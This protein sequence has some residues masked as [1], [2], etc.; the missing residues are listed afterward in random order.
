MDERIAKI[1]TA[2]RDLAASILALTGDDRLLVS[3]HGWN[4]PALNRH[5]LANMSEM[6]AIKMDAVA[7][8][9]IHEKYDPQPI[10]NKMAEFK[11][12]TLP[13]L[14]SANGVYAVP[15]YL[16]LLDYITSFFGPVFVVKT[17]WEKSVEAGS[18][19]KTISGKLLSY[20]S[21]IKKFDADFAELGGKID[22]INAAHDAATSLP[23]DMDELREARHSVI[24]LRTSAEKSEIL[25]K[26]ALDIIN[27]YLET[28]KIKEA[29]AT[30]LV[31][32]TEDA[33]S[34]ATTRGLGE[35]FQTRAHE[36]SRSMLYWVGGLVLA[37]GAGA[38]VGTLRIWAVQDLMSRNVSNEHLNIALVLAL[39]SIAGPIWFAWIATKQIGHRFRLAED[40]AFK[41]SVAKAYE[42]YRREAARIDPSFSARL[43]GSALD[44]IDEAPIRFVENHTP[45]TPWQDIFSW[46]RKGTPDA[47]NGT[48]PTRKT[49]QEE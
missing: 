35:A 25:A 11:A 33:Y 28:I 23:T 47:S 7:L 38:V 37:L 22:E 3:V 27:G 41:A 36:L 42:G 29:E 39:I 10:L 46:G 44:R 21:R 1:A 20:K 48:P 19:P 40:Y 4:L 31:Q 17:D 45:G 49:E 24:E 34:A 8:E 14:T 18:L 32:N 6:L 5:D 12:T 15:M 13:Q 26:N 30:Q 43:F 2:L 9:K 16:A